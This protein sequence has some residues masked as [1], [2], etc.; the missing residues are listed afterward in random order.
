M[1][2][3]YK[4]RAYLSTFSDKNMIDGTANTFRRKELI[5]IYFKFKNVDVIIPCRQF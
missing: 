3:I 2:Y 5:W 4:N 1:L